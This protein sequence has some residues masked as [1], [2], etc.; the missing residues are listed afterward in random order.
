MA[1]EVAEEALA[2]GRYRL[3]SRIGA[4]SA[5]SVFRAVDTHSGQDVVLKFFDGQ[6][7]GFPLWT[8]E[9]RLAMRL[10]NRN[11]AACLDVGFDQRQRLWVLVFEQAKG[12]SLRRALVSARRFTMQQI[13]RV[14]HDIASALAYAHE[15]GV[16]HREVLLIDSDCLR[17]S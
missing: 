14:L 15:Q 10:R 3:G 12:G 8:S 17:S 13:A 1:F 4:G 5:G 9:M 11:I 2:L 6:E 7:D 16:V